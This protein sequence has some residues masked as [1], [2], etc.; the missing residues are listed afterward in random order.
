M[1]VEEEAQGFGLACHPA[2]PT[3]KRTGIHVAAG[4]C[5]KEQVLDA[6]EQEGVAL[7]GAHRGRVPR[8][9][10]GDDLRQ[11]VRGLLLGGHARDYTAQRTWV[12]NAV[13]ADTETSSRYKREMMISLFWFTKNSPEIILRRSLPQRQCRRGALA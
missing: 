1:P 4:D 13:A 7:N 2:N 3:T 12:R 6:C 9:L 10:G 11:A 8:V 5:H